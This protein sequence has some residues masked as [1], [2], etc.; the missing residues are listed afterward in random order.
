MAAQHENDAPVLEA[1]SA[2]PTFYRR[3]DLDVALADFGPPHKVGPSREAPLARPLLVQTPTVTLASPL[4]DASED[5]SPPHTHLHLAPAFAEFAA[6]V[7]AAVVQAAL[8]HKDEWFGPGTHDRTVAAAFKPLCK[9]GGHLKVALPPGVGVFD[10]AGQQIAHEALAVGDAIRCILR[11]D[12]IILGRTEFGAMWTL[13]QVQARPPPPAPPS[14][15]RCLLSAEDDDVPAVDRPE[16][17]VA[18]DFQ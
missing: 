12:A 16:P 15:P 8:V 17:E 9:P 18:H 10:P 3:V 7:E 11:L 14:H 1:A 5:E 13:V 4:W 2:G 6:R